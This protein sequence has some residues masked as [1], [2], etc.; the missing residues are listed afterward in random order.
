MKKEIR[1][2]SIPDTGTIRVSEHTET[3]KVH[4]PSTHDEEPRQVKRWT[5]VTYYGDKEVDRW[6]DVEERHL[7]GCLHDAEQALKTFIERKAAVTK[8]TSARQLLTK[9]GYSE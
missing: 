5:I 4:N 2:G 3:I 8:P 7:E 9:L 6:K 1:V